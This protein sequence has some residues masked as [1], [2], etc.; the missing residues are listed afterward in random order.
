MVLWESKYITL[1]TL[2]SQE[3]TNSKA[4]CQNGL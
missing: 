3:W 2:S 1:I 4:H